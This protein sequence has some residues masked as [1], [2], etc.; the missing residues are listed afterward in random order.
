MAK[1]CKRSRVG[2]RIFP[3]APFI[4]S[5]IL[6]LLEQYS[7]LSKMGLEDLGKG[8]AAP[9]L[10]PASRHNLQISFSYLLI[11]KRTYVTAST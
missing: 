6:Y 9:P 11:D 3:S 8:S 10:Q 4:S 1:V 5:R 2:K 7:K